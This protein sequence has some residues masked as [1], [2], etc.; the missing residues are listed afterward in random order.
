MSKVFIKDIKEAL[1]RFAP[2]TLALDFDNVGLMCGSLEKKTGGVLVCLDAS[3]EVLKEAAEQKCSLVVSHHPLIFN[4]LKCV[5]T[6]SETGAAVEFALKNGITVLSYHTNLDLAE[7]GVN[8]RLAQK[9]MGQNIE[10]V[11]GGA[12]FYVEKA[13]TL[14][15]YA[16][17]IVRNLC[18]PSVKVAGRADKIISRVFCIAGAGGRDADAY[19]FARQNA[20]AFV[21]GE[22]KHNLFSSAQADDFALIEINHFNS[23]IVCLDILYDAIKSS[24]SDL[25]IYKSQQA[26]PFRT[27]EEL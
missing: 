12:L 15:E 23:E 7:G 6:E 3:L 18:D 4:A 16:K 5:D 22:F 26:R 13:T 8:F 10:L 17:Q 20:D 1:D 14:K 2:P 21:S 24:F 27:V 25:D 9:L 19:A 11:F